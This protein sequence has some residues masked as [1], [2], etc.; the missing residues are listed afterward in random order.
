MN[1]GL[2]QAT[3]ALSAASRWQ[4][5]IT[6]NIA[7][8]QAP[9]TKKGQLIMASIPVTTPVIN[10]PLEFP[11]LLPAAFYATNFE[12]GQLRRTDVPTDLAIDGPGFFEIQLPDGTVAYTRD[13][14]FHFNAQGQL[15]TKTGAFVMG[16]AG[17]IQIDPTRPGVVTISSDGEITQG[18]EQIGRIRIVRFNRPDLLT[19]IGGG[20]FLALDP[21][22]IP[23][24]VENPT[25][26]QGFLEGANTSPI[27]EM[28]NLILAMRYYEAAQ[29]LIQINDEQM[30]KTISELTTV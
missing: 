17:P 24:A 30:G 23:E 25:V 10:S 2:Y 14:E 9:A 7:A 26:R 22:L 13:G 18:D 1:V 12:P 8:S 28:A 6:D 15:V 3:A 11:T 21:Q 20:I 29:R 16:E 19:Q 4:E 5:L 27:T